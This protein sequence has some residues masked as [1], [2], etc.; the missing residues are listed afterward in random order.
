V[1]IWGEAIDH[2]IDQILF[3]FL[4]PIALALLAAVIVAVF[5]AYRFIRPVRRLIDLRLGSVQP[6]SPQL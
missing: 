4:W 2:E 5:L 1:G 3:L 6:T